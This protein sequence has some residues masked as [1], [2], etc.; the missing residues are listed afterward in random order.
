[1]QPGIDRPSLSGFEHSNTKNI[2]SRMGI[3][4]AAP[5]EKPFSCS[6]LRSPLLTSP[7]H[8]SPTNNRSRPITISQQEFSNKGATPRFTK[9]HH[10][11]TPSS[12]SS[13][14]TSTLLPGSRKQG[15]RLSRKARTTSPRPFLPSLWAWWRRERLRSPF[16][17]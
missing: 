5:R 14:R 7:S 15:D 11:I 1:M 4:R 17:G 8:Y 16:R 9:P 10:A 12:P 13:S 3:E 2:S 6:F